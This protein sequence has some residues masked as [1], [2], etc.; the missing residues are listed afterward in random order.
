MM[1]DEWLDAGNSSF[2]VHRLFAF[3][4]IRKSECYTFCAAK[5]AAFLSRPYGADTRQTA[6]L[7]S[8]R[9][10]RPRFFIACWAR[11]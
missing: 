7:S 2:I 10:R 11:T 8:G 4:D 1:N 6:T 3:L 5:M 9:F